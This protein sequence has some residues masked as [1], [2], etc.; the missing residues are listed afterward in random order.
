MLTC[1][2]GAEE[3]HA[4]GKK[5]E[6]GKKRKGVPFSTDDTGELFWSIAYKF[7]STQIQ[8]LWRHNY[9]CYSLQ[10]AIGG[11]HQLL[12]QCFLLR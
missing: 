7:V 12:H 8:H 6:A 3:K 10:K 9:I 5:P 2:A 1:L 11:F 4:Q